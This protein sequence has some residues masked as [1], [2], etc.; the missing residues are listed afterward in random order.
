ML[1][2]IILDQGIGSIFIIKLLKKKM[3]EKSDLVMLGRE[4]RERRSDSVQLALSSLKI[5]GA[6]PPAITPLG[7]T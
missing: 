4:S 1:L 7:A 3:R 2:K 5:T 6:G